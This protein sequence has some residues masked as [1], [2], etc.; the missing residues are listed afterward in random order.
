MATNTDDMGLPPMSFIDEVM[1]L[2][3]VPTFTRKFVR[4]QG[5]ASVKKD[6]KGRTFTV[7][8][9]A[10]DRIL[11]CIFADQRLTRSQ[12]AKVVGCSPSRVTEVIWA[13]EAAVKRGELENWPR[14]P[15]TASEA[16][17]DEETD[18]SQD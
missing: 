16:A 2:D 15:R 13:L 12:I 18:D 17:D 11:Q 6:P 5:P 10:A 1:P 14:L 9:P 7:G 8:G 3:Q 4:R